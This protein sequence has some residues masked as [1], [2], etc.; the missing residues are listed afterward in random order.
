VVYD[1][2]ATIESL[3]LTD[4]SL[5]AA[6]LQA[7]TQDTLA[8]SIGEQIQ[9]YLQSFDIITRINEDLFDYFDD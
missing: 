9:T 5:Y 4:S 7:I 8:P 2:I 3:R 6:T 1:S